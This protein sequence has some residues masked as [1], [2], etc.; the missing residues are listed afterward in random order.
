MH[1]KLKE[2]KTELKRTQI[3]K[4]INAAKAA[5]SKKSWHQSLQ[6]INKE[7]NKL[8]KSNKSIDDRRSRNYNV[9][10]G[11]RSAFYE[12]CK[13][14]ITHDEF[15][16]KRL[17][18][19]YSVGDKEHG[20]R[21]FE[22]REDDVLMKVTKDAHFFFPFKCVSKKY[23][24]I[25]KKII[26]ALEDNLMP[27][28]I[29]IDDDYVYIT[30]DNEIISKIELEESEQED[31][32]KKKK[33][34]KKEPYKPV[35]NRIYACDGNPIEYGCACLDWKSSGRYRII[36]TDTYILQ[37]LID[38]WFALNALGNVN[39]SDPRRIKIKNTIEHWTAEIANHMVDDAVHLHAEAFAV[40]GLSIKSGDMGRGADCNAKCNN[41]WYRTMFYNCL[42]RRCEEEGIYFLKVA[43]EYSSFEG[44][45]IFRKHLNEP[46]MNLAAMEISRRGFELYTQHIAQRRAVNTR[47]NVIFSDPHLFKESLNVSEEEIGTAISVQHSCDWK[48]RFTYFSKAGTMYR[49][50]ISQTVGDYSKLK[51]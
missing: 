13:G 25:I 35:L 49:R 46:D 4:K 47:K 42:E 48:K 9:I 31:K 18:P 7:L 32:T 12:R 30:Y 40:E 3:M 5:M 20:N 26:K 38:A 41:L 10:F 27:S 15:K 28:T 22:I 17:M 1:K 8:K 51:S 45:L 14:N 6:S 43:P 16:K 50:Y 44:N 21:L 34:K 2:T 23:K 11:T 37:K 33:N 24:T 39:S 36:K 29:Q 19:L